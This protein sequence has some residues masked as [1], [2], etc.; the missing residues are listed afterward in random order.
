MSQLPVGTST[1]LGTL[2]RLALMS[3]DNRAAHAL[4]RSY[5][6]GASAF[7]RSLRGKMAALGLTHTTLK[8]PTGLSPANRSTATDVERI[9]SAAARYPEIARDSTQLAETVNL[10][11]GPVHYRNT[12]PLVGRQDGTFNCPRPACPPWRA[13]AW[14]CACGFKDAT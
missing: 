10:E 1:T 14:S 2:L 5:P 7:E 8:E 11:N 13:A 4:S 6:G 3:S 12:N 9:V